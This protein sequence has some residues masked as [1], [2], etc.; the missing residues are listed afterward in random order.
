MTFVKTKL[1]IESMQE[2]QVAQVICS[3][4]EPLMQIPKKLI[5]QGNTIL[6]VYQNKYCTNRG[7][8]EKKVTKDSFIL[9]FIKQKASKK[10]AKIWA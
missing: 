10:E 4:G 5:E 8:I 1:L 2:G 7:N 9:V 6:G 3:S